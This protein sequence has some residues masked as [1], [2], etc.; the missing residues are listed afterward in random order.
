MRI[1]GRRG[2]NRHVLNRCRFGSWL[3]LGWHHQVW[4]G[5]MWPDEQD[6]VRWAE[7]L[8]M[9]L[10][11][12]GDA[13]EVGGIITRNRSQGD[14]SQA[15]LLWGTGRPSPFPMGISRVRVARFCL[16]GALKPARSEPQSPKLCHSLAWP[17]SRHFT[18]LSSVSSLVN[19]GY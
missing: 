12:W 10:S 9:T 5:K 3:L 8:K 14:Q 16:H 4:H 1:G 11:F 6:V 2:R 13:W 18:S 17:W 15:V 7:E 19:W